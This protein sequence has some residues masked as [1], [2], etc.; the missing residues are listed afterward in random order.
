MYIILYV[1]DEEEKLCMVGEQYKWFF[2]I[3]FCT[4]LFYFH[5]INQEVMEYVIPLEG[6]EHK[7]QLLGTNS[8]IPNT[9]YSDR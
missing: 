6:T 1:F 2:Q 4:Y 7:F 5:N 3:N 9:N 8:L